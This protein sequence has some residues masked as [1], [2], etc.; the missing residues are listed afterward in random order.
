MN[1]LII[2]IAVVIICGKLLDTL[3]GILNRILK[4]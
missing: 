3:F 1:N 2:S 4:H